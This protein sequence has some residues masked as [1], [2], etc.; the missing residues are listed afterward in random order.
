MKKD[1]NYNGFSFIST[2]VDYFLIIG[3]DPEPIVEVF[4]L[5]FDI[6]HDELNPTSYLG[7]EWETFERGKEKVHDKKRT[8][9]STSQVESSLGVQ[10]KK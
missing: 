5:K 2:H 4:K 8:K 10:L 9:E 1:P 3:T 6:R 7:L